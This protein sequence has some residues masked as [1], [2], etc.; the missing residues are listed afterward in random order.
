MPTSCKIARSLTL[1]FPDSDILNHRIIVA[2]FVFKGSKIS[3]SVGLGVGSF[4]TLIF[5]RSQ[6][7]THTN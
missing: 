2:S 7:Q 3:V 6:T 5:L 4:P 1:Q